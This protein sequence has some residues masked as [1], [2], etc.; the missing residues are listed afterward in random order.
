MTSSK[1]QALL[2]IAA[3]LALLQF[4][5]VPKI[6]QQN[7]LQQELSQVSQQLARVQAMV[8]SEAELQRALAELPG[9]QQQLANRYPQ[10]QAGQSMGQVRLNLQQQLQQQLASHQLE[11][12]VFDWVG[13]RSEA[14]LGLELNQARLLVR[15]QPAQLM[16][17]YLALFSGQNGLSVQHAELRTTA[18]GGRRSQPEATLTLLVQAIVLQPAAL[19]AALPQGVD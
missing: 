10:Q 19:D 9:L 1:Q 18:T 2:A 7:Q 3:V 11:L 5:V 12:T 15:G 13:Q 4:V 14:D 8:A 6:Q 17:G 16:Q